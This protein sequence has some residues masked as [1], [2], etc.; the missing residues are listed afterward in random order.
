MIDRRQLL[1]GL[2]LALAPVLGCAR[3]EGVTI[4]A[5]ASLETALGEIATIYGDHRGGPLR[6][7]FGASSA[8]ARQV[9]QGAPADIFISADQDWMDWLE[10]RRGLIEGSRRDLLSNRLVLIAPRDST[11]K[12]DLAPTTRL[13]AALGTGRLAVADP[14]AVPAGRYAHAALT[15]LGLWDQVRTRLVPA[16][17]V[18]TALAYVARKEAPLGIVYATDAAIEPRVRVVATFPATSHPPIIYP[19]ALVRRSPGG[20]AVLDYLAGPDAQA[21]FRRQGFLAP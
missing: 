10:S 17:T 6:L 13:A 7:V 2:G 5:A 21:I 16:E 12:L 14:Q 20:L 1:V 8:M 18:R 19:A 3:Q 9:A 4:F 11:V 15:R